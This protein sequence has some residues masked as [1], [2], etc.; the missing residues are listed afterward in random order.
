MLNTERIKW[1]I[2]KLTL[3]ELG[4]NIMFILQK[5]HD[6]STNADKLCL[7]VHPCHQYGQKTG[8]A[9]KAKNNLKAWACLSFF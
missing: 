3:T 1:P 4:V 8:T 6:G 9:L 2:C 7:T 5:K